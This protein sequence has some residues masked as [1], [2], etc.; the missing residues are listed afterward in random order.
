VVAR[1][2]ATLCNNGI[3]ARVAPG[4]YRLT[5]GTQTSRRRL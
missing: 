2:L 5:R 4:R 1:E 3:I